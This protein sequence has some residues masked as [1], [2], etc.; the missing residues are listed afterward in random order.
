[1]CHAAGVSSG[2]WREITPALVLVLTIESGNYCIE[3]GDGS[4][5]KSTYDKVIFGC[6]F[7]TNIQF[8]SV[9]GW[10]IGLSFFHGSKVAP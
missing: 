8:F 3:I 2:K 4:T 6:F 7:P 9:V 10:D 5:Q 1:M